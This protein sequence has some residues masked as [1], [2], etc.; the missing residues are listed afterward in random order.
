MKF[1]DLGKQYLAYR[2]EIDAAIHKVLDSGQ[3]I[4]GQP[5]QDLEQTLASYVGTAY[6]VGVSS[7]TDGLLLA[8]MAYEVRPGDEIIT[9]PFTFVAT[10]EVISFLNARPVFVDID[11]L[12]FNLDVDHLADILRSR[13]KSGGRVKGIIPVSLY[14]QC[15]D[16]DTINDIASANGLFV[17]EDAC[18]SLGARFK[19]RRSCNLSD[20]GITS[21]FPSKPLGCYGDGGM[22]FTNNQELAGRI[23]T[24]RVHGQSVRYQHE[25]I[26]LN[27]RLDTIQAA[28]VLAK[29]PHLEEEIRLREKAARNYSMLLR[30]NLPEVRPPAVLEDR[31]SVYA[32]YTI[33]VP[34]GLR[35]AVVQRLKKE[36][37]PTAVHYPNP[38]HLQPAFRYL[39]LGPG[40]F[41]EAELAAK[42]VL[43]LPMH[44]FISMEE[45]EKVING[46]KRAVEA[47]VIK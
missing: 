26:G 45:Q 34:E 28:I 18:Q 6:A 5:V 11:P 23:K 19:E 36:G 25:K 2:D 24:L 27:A 47:L 37:I 17:I 33:R 8:L 16:M 21:F 43:S 22:V 10:A 44:P 39:G 12:T 9:T 7:G 30:E 1:V 40:S 42:E 32:Q 35:D 41:P 31:T 20:V 29:F 38:L 4:L 14:G 3:F 46:L 13:Q 15:P